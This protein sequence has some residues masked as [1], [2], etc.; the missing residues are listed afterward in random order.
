MLQWQVQFMLQNMLQDFFLLLYFSTCCCRLLQA[1]CWPSP[2]SCHHPPEPSP[3]S[4]PHPPHSAPPPPHCHLTEQCT[5]QP[6]LTLPPS[7]HLSSLKCSLHWAQ[8]FH[9]HNQ[10]PH[11]PVPAILTWPDLKRWTLENVG[12]RQGRHE[13]SLKE[14]PVCLSVMNSFR[15]LHNSNLRSN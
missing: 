14:F 11:C 9:C 1:S 5:P 4:A 2:H 8:V 7:L 3:H 15:L 6:A 13:G 10:G 12:G